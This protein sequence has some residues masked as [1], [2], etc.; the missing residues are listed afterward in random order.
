MPEDQTARMQVT[1]D[2]AAPSFVP[3]IA[4]HAGRLGL[5]NCAIAR[6]GPHLSIKATGAPEMLEA[7][8]LACTLGPAEVMVDDVRCDLD[9]WTN[10]PPPD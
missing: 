7:L 9:G 5:R 6:K 3:W 8:A 10:G 1:G 4:R 2:I